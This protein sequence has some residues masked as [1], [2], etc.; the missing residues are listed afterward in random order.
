MCGARRRQLALR[1]PCRARTRSGR[2]DARQALHGRQRQRHRADLACHLGWQQ[3]RNVEWHYIAPGKP[4]Q[5]GFIESFNGRLR[6]ECLN[7]HLFTKP[8]RGQTDYRSMEDRLQHQATTHEPGWAHTDGVCRHAPQRGIT[9]TDS[10]YERGIS[11]ARQYFMIQMYIP[12]S[13]KAV[14]TF[15]IKMADRI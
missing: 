9:R 6:D 2:R 12:Q 5:N 4:T 8:R 1:R 14:W 15:A 10:P 7:E 11:G 3:D 13:Q